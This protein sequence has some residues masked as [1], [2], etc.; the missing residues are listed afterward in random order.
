[1]KL[2][3]V[4]IFY[5]KIYRNR[6][7]SMSSFNSLKIQIIPILFNILFFTLSEER[8]PYITNAFLVINFYCFSLVAYTVAHHNHSRFFLSCWYYR[9]SCPSCWCCSG[10]RPSCFPKNKG[11]LVP[12]LPH[13]RELLGISSSSFF[14]ANLSPFGTFDVD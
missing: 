2:F 14:M 9:S 12:L 13:P 11:L 1:M 10:K 7:I 8:R 5:M 4:H 3:S 6:K